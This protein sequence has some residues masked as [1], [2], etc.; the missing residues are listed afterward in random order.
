[1]HIAWG[2]PLLPHFVA[3]FV[4]ITPITPYPAGIGSL[5]VVLWTMSKAYRVVFECPKGGHTVNLQRKCAKPSLSEVEA[6]ELFGD[7]KISC[8]SPNCGWN[9]KVSKMRLLRILP[10]NWVFSP[11]T[12]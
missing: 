4:N 1:M 5:K 12:S 3:I 10:F 11:T 2:E 9:G 7:E 8:E 6:L